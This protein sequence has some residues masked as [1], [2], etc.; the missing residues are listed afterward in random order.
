MN[1]D[2]AVV[3]RL[4]RSS[5]IDPGLEGIRHR[6]G[7]GSPGRDVDHSDRFESPVFMR[8]VREWFAVGFLWSLVSPLLTYIRHGLM[9]S[10]V[11]YAIW[12]FLMYY[13]RPQT[14]ARVIAEFRRRWIECFMPM[15]WWYVILL[16]ILF[17][18]G[19]TGGIHL[20]YCTTCLMVLFM[21][22]SL[23]AQYDG[24]SRRI[25]IKTIILIA[26]ECLWSLPHLLAMPTLPRMRMSNPSDYAAEAS[27]AG[28][29]DYSYYTALA[30]LVPVLL[31][32]VV[33]VRSRLSKFLYLLLVVGV[34]VTVS[35]ATFMGAA[36]LTAGGGV[37]FAALSWARSK[38]RK[39]SWGLIV[40]IV[41]AVLIWQTSLSHTPQ[42]SFIANKFTLEIERIRVE[43]IENDP[44]GRGQ[45]DMISIASFERSPLIG[46]G[47]Y[48]LANNPGLWVLVG[49][50]SSWFDQLAEYGLLGFLPIVA[51]LL[52]RTL[53]VLRG[54][55]SKRAT[56][57]AVAHLVTLIVYVV[58]GT[59]N[60]VLFIF[61][62]TVVVFMLAPGVVLIGREYKG[63]VTNSNVAAEERG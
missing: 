55:T 9:L 32:L 57:E 39:H 4:D 52:L 27:L 44:T 6:R 45:L 16:N 46:V 11:L 1:M 51:F 31:G 2:Y 28:I 26:A 48:T 25:A 43:G 37:L 22:V 34:T 36:L 35:L 38:T 59:F 29:G 49:G 8:S 62:I 30:M 47:P 10:W 54:V 15:V 18:R 58:G 13:E 23:A 17:S 42:G 40:L 33:S 14:F 19:L 20:L 60:P 56:N 63:A 61:P 3:S 12:L 7:Y 24:S 50:H 5:Y 53:R 41:L 21:E